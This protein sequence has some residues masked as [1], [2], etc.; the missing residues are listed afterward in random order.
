[1]DPP[2]NQRRAARN[3]DIDNLASLYR[4][5]NDD[6]ALVRRLGEHVLSDFSAIVEEFYAWLPNLEEY[7]RFFQNAAQIDRVK[8]MQLTYWQ[9]FFRAELDERYAESRRRVGNVH[10]TIGLSLDAY[11]ASMNTMLTLILKKARSNGF[12]AEHEGAATA[13][14]TKLT[15]LDTSIVVKA[16]SVLTAETLAAQTDAIMAMSTPITAVW[17]GILML[18]VVGIID[19]KR[20]RDIMST[21][22]CRIRESEAR[23]CILDISGVAMVDIAVANHFIKISKATRLMGCE[24]IISGLSP[25]VTQSIVELGVDVDAMSTR[26]TLKDALAIAFARTGQRVTAA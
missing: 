26:A 25:A 14:L 19:A 2:L 7:A 4:L 6:L 17:A 9:E 10:A 24:C 12:P 3:L 16:F 1:M 20:A 15:H 11:F 8:R 13:A 21:T 22:L 23:V 18:P 5:S